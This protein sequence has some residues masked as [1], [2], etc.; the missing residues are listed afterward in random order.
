MK[1]REWEAVWEKEVKRNDMKAT[2]NFIFK[3]CSIV[4]LRETDSL[5]S[6]NSKRLWG[7]QSSKTQ[8]RRGRHRKSISVP[9]AQAVERGSGRFAHPCCL[10]EGNCLYDIF[11]FLRTTHSISSTKLPQPSPLLLP[12]WQS[13]REV[14][15][16]LQRDSLGF[17][18]IPMV[19]FQPECGSSFLVPTSFTASSSLPGTTEVTLHRK[20]R[21]WSNQPTGLLVGF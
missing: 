7:K 15:Y 2:V 8:P 1:K 20:P 6:A 4:S 14:K 11:G 12:L 16:W 3:M 5:L 9:W 13:R 19:Y 17:H 21:S 18:R 10:A